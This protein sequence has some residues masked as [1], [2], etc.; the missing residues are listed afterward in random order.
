MKKCIITLLSTSVL[1]TSLNSFAFP[2]NYSQSL[3][4]KEDIKIPGEND[5]AYVRWGK[6]FYMNFILQN[7]AGVKKI[8]GNLYDLL[9]EKSVIMKNEGFFPE[10]NSAYRESIIRRQAPFFIDYFN[11]NLTQETV[12]DIAALHFKFNI[13]A[14]MFDEMKYIIVESFRE[15]F[16]DFITYYIV[17][18][19]S[20]M[21]EFRSMVVN[22][23]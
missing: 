16:G 2:N 14:E 5:L 20:T 11:G 4:N 10:N 6:Q 19:G 12:N 3:V 13:T 1:A 15:S 9:A 8:L 23:N 22:A 18:P 17:D 21:E 7:E